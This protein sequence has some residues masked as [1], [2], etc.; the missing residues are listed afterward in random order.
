MTTSSS[1]ILLSRPFE[2][3]IISNS[4]FNCFTY[5]VCEVIATV[6]TSYSMV[7][8]VTIPKTAEDFKHIN[9]MCQKYKK[10][11]Q[12]EEDDSQ[13]QLKRAKTFF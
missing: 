13:K 1:M 8:K 9:I 3:F 12:R 10:T 5:F 2:F 6:S 7:P 11:H 4:S